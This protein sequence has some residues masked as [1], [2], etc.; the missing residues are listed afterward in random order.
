ML[1]L[2]STEASYTPRACRHDLSELDFL[3]GRRWA[4]A[5]SQNGARKQKDDKSQ[6][7]GRPNS[8]D[9]I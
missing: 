2:M 8:A 7:H 3:K 4:C 9:I 1:G 6:V 5:D